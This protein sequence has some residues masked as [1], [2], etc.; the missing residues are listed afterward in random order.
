MAQQFEQHI[1]AN[2]DLENV[3]T[4]PVSLGDC[5]LYSHRAPDKATINEDAAAV[6]SVGSESLVLIVADGLGGERAGA[7][8][9]RMAVDIL[10]QSIYASTQSNN[11]REA[12]LDGMESANAAVRALGTGAATT[13]A[14]VEI[15]GLKLRS[16]H[17]GD[18]IILVC[19]QRGRI[20][21]QTLPHSPT[22]YA[23][24]AGLLDEADAPHHSDRHIVSNVVGSD[25][26]RIDIGPA[27]TLARR[28]T[29][30]LASDGLSDNLYQE[31]IIDTIRSG[32]LN[33]VAQKLVDIT[34][35]RMEQRS[36]HHPGKPDDLTF[37]IYRPSH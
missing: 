35:T 13:L 31:E 19:G 30:I 6:I 28:D 20:K 34:Q 2:T 8:A 25:E 10:T 23:Q 18:S 7:Q 5:A 17:V 37:I 22:G 9:A 3:R 11:I 16:Y 15:N 33:R 24:E 26:M 1:I 27:L 14:V 12:I 36:D 29:V 21:F 32:I 4:L